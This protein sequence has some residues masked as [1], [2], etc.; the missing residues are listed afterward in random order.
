[1]MKKE[2]IALVCVLLA[3]TAVLG[4]E[5]SC[6]LSDGLFERRS[7]LVAQVGT[8]EGET[9]QSRELKGINEKYFQLMSKLES[10]AKPGAAQ[11]GR[12]CCGSSSHDPIASLVCK[13]SAY[14][15]SGRKQG[16]LL[17]ESVPTGPR[18][19]EALWALDEI[20]HLH[21][22]DNHAVLFGPYGPVTLYLDELYRLV[23]S[24]N[25]EALS[26]YLGIYPHSDGEHG[27][28]MDDQMK[29]LMTG[30]TGLVL[31]EL[32]TVIREFTTPT[33]VRKNE[34]F[35]RFDCTVHWGQVFGSVKTNRSRAQMYRTDGSFRS[36]ME[37]R[38]TCRQNSDLEESRS[39]SQR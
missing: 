11:E 17:L 28:Q 4:A 39:E 31:R 37:S 14:L 10:S 23:R 5:D 12:E 13:L 25:E 3:G 7:A 33:R 1:M 8:Y 36:K 6:Q 38:A 22:S 27:E 24:G 18:G 21:D 29:K 30:D 20:A 2:S 16:K 32:G 15:A 35:V 9:N 34:D 26:K 19:R